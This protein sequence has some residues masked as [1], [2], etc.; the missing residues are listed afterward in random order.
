MNLQNPTD[1]DIAKYIKGFEKVLCKFKDYIDP[2]NELPF[3]FV[4]H[5]I[6]TFKEANE[7]ERLKPNT[8]REIVAK[9]NACL[10]NHP[11]NC[12]PILKALVENDQTHIAKFIVSS[13]KNTYSPDRVL[14]KEER[15]AI[16]ENMFCLE[17]LVSTRV[18]DFLVL[19][20]GVK[21]ITSNHREWIISYKTENKDVYQLFE[22]IKRRSLRHFNDFNNCLVGTGQNQIVE[23]LRKGGVVEITNYLEGI[24]NRTDLDTIEI[25]IIQKLSGYVFNKNETKLSEEQLFFIDK[26]IALLNKKENRIKF[27]GSYRTNSI[28][29]YFQCETNDSQEWLFDFCKND[30]LKL[31]LQTVFRSL[32]PEL[33]N[34]PKFDIDVCMT[35]YSKIHS[36][37]SRCHQSLGKIYHYKQNECYVKRFSFWFECS[38]EYSIF[39]C[40]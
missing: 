3:C 28:A 17:K 30:E 16:D 12:L 40:E 10:K 2:L 7:I 14:T 6:M 23:V 39:T 13:G 5:R 21:C 32:Q 1:T 9:M 35:N 38:L 22:V 24:D 31:E 29:L 25:G 8:T 33:N 15:D 34:F 18:N 27:V 19:L 26:L 36:I 37:F 20:V 4:E 11:E